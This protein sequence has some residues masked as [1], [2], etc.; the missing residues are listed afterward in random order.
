[1]KHGR[2]LS[3]GGAVVALTVVLTAVTSACSTSV[4]DLGENVP[5]DAA[6]PTTTFPSLAEAG[7]TPSAYGCAEWI[8][9]EVREERLGA[10][11]A[12]CGDV[13][14]ENSLFPLD[15]KKN[16]IAGTAGQWLRCSGSFGPDDTVGVEFAPGCRL[17]FLQR[18]V[19]GKFVRGTVARLQAKFDIHDPRPAGQPRKLDVHFPDDRHVTYELSVGKCP[20]VLRLTSTE[21]GATKTVDFTPATREDPAF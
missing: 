11:G 10:C 12:Q 1:M 2:K 21:N 16:V 3:L 4:L 18:D 15:S 7:V 5:A 13:A 9:D 6:S 19:D 14:S 8:D 20:S 17:Y